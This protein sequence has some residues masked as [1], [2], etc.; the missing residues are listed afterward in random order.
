MCCCSRVKSL[1]G[2]QIVGGIHSRALEAHPKVIV[3]VQHDNAFA[4]AVAIIL[5]FTLLSENS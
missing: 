2:L 4:N 5:G 1:E 3:Y